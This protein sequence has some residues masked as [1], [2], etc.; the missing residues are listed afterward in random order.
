MPVFIWTT[1]AHTHTQR[2]TVML[3]L[4]DRDNYP[5]NSLVDTVMSYVVDGH[6]VVIPG[7]Y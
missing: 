4:D 1:A 3:G 7:R 6:V 2:R 5:S